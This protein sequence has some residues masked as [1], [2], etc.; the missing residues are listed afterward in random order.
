MPNILNRKRVLLGLLALAIIAAAVFLSRQLPLQSWLHQIEALGWPGHLV[1]ILL[2]VVLTVLLIPGSVLTLGAGTIYGLWKGAATVLIGANLAALCSFLL[3]RTLLRQRVGVWAAGNPKFAALDRAIG[4]NGFKMVLLSRLS[5]IFPFTLLNYFLGL[6]TVRT[7]AYVLA[8]LLGMLP[9]TFMYV[10]LGTAARDAL[11]GSALSGWQQ[12][13][14]YGGLLATIAIVVL[15]TRIARK[16]MAE[17][18]LQSNAP[19]EQ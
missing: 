4:R 1:F 13:L 10:Y 6:T 11:S 7:G 9:G 16:A 18:E 15:I 8:N 3:A 17:A 12:A 14:R 19:E 5:P 2:Y